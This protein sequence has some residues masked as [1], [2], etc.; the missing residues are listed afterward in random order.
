MAA[1][2]EW[3]IAALETAP[4]E[5]GLTDVVKTGHWTASATEVDGDDTYTGSAYGSVGFGEPDPDSFVDYPNIT[6][7]EAITWVQETLGA[8]QVANIEAGLLA[9]IENQKNPPIVTL[10]L[11]WTQN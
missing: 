2:P 6:E 4:S 9:Q 11:P 5:D 7:A 10:P 3:H 1:T 8:E